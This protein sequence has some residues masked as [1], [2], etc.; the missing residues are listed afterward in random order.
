MLPDVQARHRGAELQ[1]ERSIT[2]APLD[3]GAALD[4]ER[5][6]VQRVHDGFLVLRRHGPI[7][8]RYHEGPLVAR[9]RV[10]SQLDQGSVQDTRL[11]IRL[12]PPRT[13]LQEPPHYP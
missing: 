9:R 1:A 5:A 2:V 7:A 12:L 13:R 11:N 10:E 6:P 8:D 3:E 4:D